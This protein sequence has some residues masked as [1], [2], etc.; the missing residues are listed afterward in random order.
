MRWITHSRQRV[1]FIG[2]RVLL[3]V[4][5]SWIQSAPATAAMPHTVTMVVRTVEQPA[6]FL[7]SLLAADEKSGPAMSV[8]RVHDRH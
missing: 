1:L 8:R 6:R 3:S 7:L 4:C 2:L 5:S